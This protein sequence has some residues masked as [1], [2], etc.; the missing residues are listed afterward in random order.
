MN[1]SA[2]YIA[3]CFMHQKLRVYEHSSIARQRDEIE[4][5]IAD[6]VGQMD[7]GLYHTLAGY[8]PEFLLT[9]SRFE[10]DLRNAVAMLEQLL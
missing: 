9:H 3:Y 8:T 1:D 6:Y 5:S 10:S 2:V 7:Q 4:T